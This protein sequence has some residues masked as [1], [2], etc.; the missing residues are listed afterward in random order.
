MALSTMIVGLSLKAV[1]HGGRALEGMGQTQCL[2]APL[3]PTKAFP[4]KAIIL[5]APNRNLVSLV[6]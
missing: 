4:T 6:T 1:S 3:F 2:L 5:L